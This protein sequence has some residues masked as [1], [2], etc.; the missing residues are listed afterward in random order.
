M[1]NE[2]LQLLVEKVSLKDFHQPFLHVAVF[3]SRLKTTGGRYHL[4]DHHLDFNPKMFTLGEETFVKIIRHELCHY[5]LHL[6]GLPHGHKDQAFKK[7]LQ[8]VDG[9]RYAPQVSE[10]K[11]LVYQ[12]QHCGTPYV[13]QRKLNTKRF[14]C[15]KCHGSLVFKETMTG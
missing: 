10:K 9:L 8:K 5:H 13:R 3:N 2:Q 7:L 15:S 6:K 14:V 1:T 12:C 11:Y 4:K